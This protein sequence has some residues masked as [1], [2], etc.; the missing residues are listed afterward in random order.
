MATEIPAPTT[1]STAEAESATEPRSRSA[2]AEGII[3]R[4]VYWALGLGV[5]PV[6][7]FDV[8]AVAAVE[9]KMLKELSAVYE[10]EFSRGIAKKLIY[11]LLSSAGIV[12][13]GTLLAGSLAKLVP[14]VGTAL[15]LMSVP[16]VVG[17]F[18]HGLGQ[19]LL[20]HFESGGTLLDFDPDAMRQHFKHEFEKAKEV[21]QKMQHGDAASARPKA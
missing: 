21:V 10:V 11:S 5:I 3:R 16:V 17:A 20:M 14:L 15:G 18:T 2:Q 6:P 13:M 1:S 19:V 12:G 4:N 9:M 7:L 8:A